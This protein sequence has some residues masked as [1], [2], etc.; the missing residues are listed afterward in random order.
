MSSM[1]VNVDMLEQMD[2]MDISDQEALDVFLNSGG[3]E[4]TLL[5]PI[6]G[7]G[8]KPADIIIITLSTVISLWLGETPC[9]KLFHSPPE[10]G[11]TDVDTRHTGGRSRGFL[12]GSQC[13]SQIPSAN[14]AFFLKLHFNF[15]LCLQ[16]LTWVSVVK[17]TRFWGGGGLCGSPPSLFSRWYLM[18]G[19][20]P[21]RVFSRQ[22][23][24]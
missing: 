24:F 2:L 8:E 10:S 21:R 19:A 3:E 12:K 17:S 14:R 23:T 22:L 7:R 15:F 6:S 4:N 13:F 11:V 16:S 1:E 9:A 18:L 20:R 5:S